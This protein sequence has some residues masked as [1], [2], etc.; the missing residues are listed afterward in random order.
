VGKLS[1]G[2]SFHPNEQQPIAQVGIRSTPW[3]DLYMILGGVE[4]DGSAATLKIMVNP[5]VMWIW[6]GG[7]I[8]TMGALITLIPSRSTRTPAAQTLDLTA[9]GSASSLEYS[10]SPR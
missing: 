1:P 10:G 3:E 5:M 6:I 2:K 4:R 9:G 8:I 7:V